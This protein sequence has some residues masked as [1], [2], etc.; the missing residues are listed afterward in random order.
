[1]DGLR[2]V[3]SHI[4]TGTNPKS[5][6]RGDKATPNDHGSTIPEQISDRFRVGKTASNGCPTHQHSRRDA[7]WT[8]APVNRYSYKEGFV[9]ADVGCHFRNHIATLGIKV[10]L[11]EGISLRRWFSKGPRSVNKD[12]RPIQGGEFT[13]KVNDQPRFKP[14]T[15]P[16]ISGN[17]AS[18]QLDDD[19]SLGGTCSCSHGSSGLVM[20]ATRFRFWVVLN[21]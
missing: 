21:M 3:R 17:E 13:S 8:E 18:S 11:E 16:G 9:P 12:Q 20:I 7:K 10:P 2:E 15:G 5:G 4:V 6:W 1:M 19:T 14:G